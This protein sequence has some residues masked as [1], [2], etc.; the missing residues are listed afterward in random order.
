MCRGSKPLLNEDIFRLQDDTS[1]AEQCLA[2]G[3]SEIKSDSLENDKNSSCGIGAC[4]VTRSPTV[5][6][7]NIHE[8]FSPLRIESLERSTGASAVDQKSLGSKS[9][10]NC[11][12]CTYEN[13]PKATKCVM[14]GHTATRIS[15]VPSSFKDTH[16]LSP[17]WDFA[18]AHGAANIEESFL[19]YKKPSSHRLDDLSDLSPSNTNNAELDRLR[20]T[21]CNRKR[22][23]DWNWLNACV[24]I[25]QGDANAVETYLSSGGD[26]TRQLTQ[27]ECAYLNRPSAFDVGYTLVHLAIRFHREDMLATILSYIEGSGSGVKRVPSYVAPDLASD[28]RRHV[29]S[30]IKQQRK[31]SF[32]CPFVTEL[33]TFTL[34]AEIEDLP[35]IIQ[36]Q[37]FEELL[38]KDAQ[39]QLEADP[40]VINWSLEVTAHLGSRLYALWNRSAGD[41]LLDSL[42]QATWGV[43]D[44]DNILRRALADLLNN[45]S[46]VFY[47]YWKEYE[48]SQARLLHFSLEE[49]QWE[50]EWASLVS[51]A[52]QPGAS[53]EQLHIFAL[54]HI[55]RRPIIVYGVKYVK[56][57]RGEPIGFA[58]FEGVYL[59]LLWEPSFCVRSPLSL[60]YTR[61][62]FSALVTIE[63]YSTNSI[64]NQNPDSTDNSLQVA[65]LPLMDHQRKLLPV[66]FV[67]PSETGREE[68]LLRQWLDVCV[69]DSGLLVAQQKLYKRPLLVAQMLEEWLNHYRRLAQMS[70]APFVRPIPVQD[71]S[72]DGDSDDE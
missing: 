30:T 39:Q 22:N 42:M 8:H 12:S 6:A 15:P 71:Y 18:S 34:P 53:L 72:S 10:W 17:E 63:P 38:D 19:P 65:F 7:S 60:G 24:G 52:S 2:S 55:L 46:H 33:T 27:M 40:P 61:G 41:C 23:P 28:I 26:P 62:H 64:S 5:T 14:C 9:K 70:N 3:P 47:P 66:H 35:M 1:P 11:Q 4:K 32:P 48:A 43:F 45:G 37:L 59:P 67:M 56:S 13:W 68:N 36:E 58:R 54:A 44:R 21:Q 57:Y 51:L 29:A 69:T 50:E 49:G 25:V 31:A 20:R 16:I